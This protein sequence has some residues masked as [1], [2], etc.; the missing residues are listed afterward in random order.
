VHL[1]YRAQSGLAPE[2]QTLLVAGD[3]HRGAARTPAAGCTHPAAD[4][5]AG[6]AA[7]EDIQRA[8]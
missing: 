6:A 2:V 3:I 8:V 7:E 5:P 1:G 4:S